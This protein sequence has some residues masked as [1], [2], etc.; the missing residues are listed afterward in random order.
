MY[1]EK[2]MNIIKCVE[3][4]EGSESELSNK[5]RKNNYLVRDLSNRWIE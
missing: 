3:I 5:A 1:E 4:E 2:K